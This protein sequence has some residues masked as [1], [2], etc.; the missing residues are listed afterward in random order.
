MAR[1]ELIEDR[2][3]EAGVAYV[4][5]LLLLAL[6]S[7]MGFAFLVRVGTRTSATTT[8][9]ANMQARYLAE[10]AA[11]HAL[12]R[13]LNEPGFPA[14]ETVYSMHSLGDGRYGYKV[15]KPTETKFGTVATLGAIGDSVTYQSYVQYIPAKVMTVYGDKDDT[16]PNYRQ[17]VGADWTNANDTVDIL[18]DRLKWVEVEGCPF[19]NE[20]VM[21]TIDEDNDIDVA[22]WDGTGWGNHYEFAQNVDRNYKCFDVAY[23]NLSGDALAVG[24]IDGTSAVYFDIWD[25]SAWV[26]GSPQVAFNVSSGQLRTLVMASKPGTDQILIA[27]VNSKKRLHLAN[28][29]GSTFTHMGVIEAETE[30]TTFGVAEIVHEQQ[31][32]DAIILWSRGDASRIRYRIWD[33]CTLS[34]TQSLPVIGEDD[35]ALIIRADADPTSDYV[36]VA[37]A[38]SD[39]E[40]DVAVWDGDAW[41][42]S[43]RADT[44]REDGA[45]AINLDVAWEGRGN[46]AL[47]VWGRSGQ[48]WFRYFSWRKGALLSSVTIQSSPN[49]G[50]KPRG[51]RLIPLSQS[52]KILLVA[53][54]HAKDVKACLWIGNKFV[55]NSPDLFDIDVSEEG[56]LP[57]D[58]AEMGVVRAGGAGGT[59]CAN[60]PPNVS[61]GPDD[62]VSLPAID[63]ALNGTVADD[64]L[65]DPPAAVTTVWS[66]T[67]GPDTMTFGDASQV[68]T[69][70]TY[71]QA[72]VYVLRLTAGDGAL[73]AFDEVEITVEDS[74]KYIE[75]H[76]PW[77][78]AGSGAWLV[79]DLS[80]APYNVP[81]DSV[82]EVA[83]TNSNEVSASRGGLRAAGSS[84]ERE[85][86][87]HEA[88]GGGVDAVVMN[89]QSDGTSRIE[90]YAQSAASVEFHLLGCWTTGHYTETWNSFKAGAYGSWRDIPLAP[91]GVGPGQVAEIL[92]YNEEKSFERWVGVRTDGS[93]LTRRLDLHEA[94]P[95]AYNFVSMFVKAGGDANATIEV[96][97]ENNNDVTFVLIGYWD[98]PPGTYVETATDLGPAGADSTWGDENLSAFGVPPLAVAQIVIANGEDGGE[99]MQ[100]LRENGSSLARVLN[101]HEAESGGLDAA[102]MHVTAD[103]NSVIERYHQD[104]SKTHGFYLYGYWQ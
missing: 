33:G 11:N 36:L 71:P 78:P 102:T 93:G 27:A 42:D 28:W 40:I 20:F 69:T 46:E 21:G 8:R 81:P 47:V 37:A 96:Y 52:D 5:I 19:R 70:A 74:R 82:V 34:T 87:I 104:V 84:L 63:V 13:I 64:G 24:R 44:N 10:S 61:A 76:Q 72:G 38:D 17:L 22:V 53:N 12:W 89:V 101:L 88:E 60:Q 90:Y 25:G 99:Y 3:K 77:S 100:G 97:T 95:D 45:G 94:E 26:Y 80:G 92:C 86:Q 39:K 79:K 2:K 73:E 62:T 58:V 65:P 7:T 59:A 54:N 49:F 51:T 68:D 35:E 6:V 57:F 15:R 98:T 85:L 56:F 91:Y 48:F 14:S 23:E 4:A 31:S 43:W 16:L 83:I 1:V 50:E 66:Q 18:R 9:V 30:V 55:P 32:G 29:T 103:N 67:S 75:A 41:I